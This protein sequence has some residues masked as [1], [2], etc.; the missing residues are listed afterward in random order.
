MR[1]GR[2]TRTTWKDHFGP[3]VNWNSTMSPH[4]G[5]K[6]RRPRFP[7]PTSLAKRTSCSSDLW[8]HID[9]ESFFTAVAQHRSLREDSSFASQSFWNPEGAYMNTNTGS[10]CSGLDSNTVLASIYIFDPTASCNSATFQ[11]YSDRA[12][13]NL[14]LEKYVD[15]SSRVYLLKKGSGTPP[16][17]KTISRLSLRR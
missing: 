13:A 3:L 2:A 8:E 9:S 12:L 15:S 4:A 10:E 14:N 5:R 16:S 1:C 7:I 6:Q 11:P 17:P